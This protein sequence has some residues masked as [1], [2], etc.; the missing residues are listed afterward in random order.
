MLPELKFEKPANVRRKYKNICKSG[1]CTLTLRRGARA[2]FV[3]RALVG[4]VPKAINVYQSR[5]T[6][7]ASLRFEPSF[8]FFHRRHFFPS[9]GRTLIKDNLI[10]CLI[11]MNIAIRVIQACP[12]SP[13]FASLSSVGADTG[14]IK[15]CVSSNT[16][17]SKLKRSVNADNQ[18]KLRNFGF[19]CGKAGHVP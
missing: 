15:V 17:W 1:R 2:S 16:R 11:K 13:V 8:S 19:A 7:C 9:P 18:H 6:I 10:K 14:R 4:A 3:P 12:P 5:V